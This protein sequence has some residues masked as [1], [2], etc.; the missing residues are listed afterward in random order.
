MGVIFRANAL[1]LPLLFYFFV[2]ILDPHTLLWVFYFLLST[3]DIIR[4][5]EQPIGQ[6]G[7]SLAFILR[8]HVFPIIGL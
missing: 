8:G 6:G 3:S 5:T 2:F 1:F 4:D 7:V